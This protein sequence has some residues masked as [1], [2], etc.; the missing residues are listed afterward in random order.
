MGIDL[1]KNKDK[2]FTLYARFHLHIEGKGRGL[3]LAQTQMF[4]LGGKIKIESEVDIGTTFEVSFK[5][6]PNL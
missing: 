2:L 3:Y 4:A 6:T 1:Q 5:R